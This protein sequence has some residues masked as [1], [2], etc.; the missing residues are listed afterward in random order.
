[1]AHTQY[2]IFLPKVS[3][4][5]TATR[6][7]LIAIYHEFHLTVENIAPNRR[8]GALRHRVRRAPPAPGNLKISAASRH[9][10]QLNA[11]EGALN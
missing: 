1:M 6:F 5:E 8:I 11:S 3:L 9:A 4:H 7:R 10:V 2:K